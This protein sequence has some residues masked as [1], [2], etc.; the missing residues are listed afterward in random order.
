MAKNIITS[1]IK[2]L[3]DLILQKILDFIIKFLTPIIKEIQEFIISEQFAAYM[4]IIRLLLSWYNKGVM[5]ANRLNAVLNS[6]L[7]KFKNDNY[8]SN[9]EDYDI[10]TILD[11]VNYADI[12]ETEKSE[13]EPIINN[14]Q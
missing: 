10:P 9:G 4:A 3:R 6:M 14:C 1:L 13:K 11:N 2:E 5:T 12:Y 7:S 8:G